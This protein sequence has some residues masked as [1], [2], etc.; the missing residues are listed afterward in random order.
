MLHKR[1]KLSVVSKVSC[2]SN[3]GLRTR[4]S[5]K[6]SGKDFESRFSAQLS[7]FSTHGTGGVHGVL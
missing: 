5:Y 4:R 7:R 2:D 6:E 3:E 1:D